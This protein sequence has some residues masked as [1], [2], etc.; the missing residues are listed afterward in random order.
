MGKGSKQIGFALSNISTEQFAII[1]E[2]Y[3][4]SEKIQLNTNIRFGADDKIHIISCFVEILFESAR[5]QLLKI[6]VGCHFHIE[7]E[8]W[9]ELFETEKRLIRLPKGFLIHLAFLTVGTVRG[10]LHS[11]TEGTDFNKYVL[12]IIDVAEII[13]DDAVLK[14]N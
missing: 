7:D 8:S 5:R 12:P 1:N 6:E 11:K 4:S 3:D 2:E 9:I 14:L 10:I 13:K